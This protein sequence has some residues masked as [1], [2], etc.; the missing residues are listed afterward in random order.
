MAQVQTRSGL[1]KPKKDVQFVSPCQG[2]PLEGE[3]GL[4]AL[5]PPNGRS[6]RPRGQMPWCVWRRAEG[7]VL[8]C[9]RRAGVGARN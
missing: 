4:D 3:C 7:E 2:C 8:N 9:I 1:T 6:N 5:P